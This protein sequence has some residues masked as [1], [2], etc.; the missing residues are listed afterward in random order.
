MKDYSLLEDIYW[1]DLEK[2]QGEYGTKEITRS[3]YLFALDNY[4]LIPNEL[5]FKIAQMMFNGVVKNK[6]KR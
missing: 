3:E 2:L 5:N 1:G 4:A 6:S